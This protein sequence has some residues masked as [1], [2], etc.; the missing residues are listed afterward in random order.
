MPKPFSQILFHVILMTINHLSYFTMRK[1]KLRDFKQLNCLVTEGEIEA[2]TFSPYAICSFWVFKPLW[3]KSPEL[4]LLHHIYRVISTSMVWL[5]WLPFLVL[6]FAFCILLF[7]LLLSGSWL[8]PCWL[9]TSL[10]VFNLIFK[11]CLWAEM[12]KPLN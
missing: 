2:A 4:F 7:P 6:D 1:Q 10:T 11:M 5:Q 9:H 8:T 3:I 12:K